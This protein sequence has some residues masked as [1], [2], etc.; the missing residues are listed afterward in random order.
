M[1]TRIKTVQEW[2]W[3]IALWCGG[4][5]AASLLGYVVRWMIK[6]S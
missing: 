1:K 6:V 4:L 5:A 3:F 2:L